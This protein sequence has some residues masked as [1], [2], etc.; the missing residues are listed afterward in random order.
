M[1]N[2]P[3]LPP[4]LAP[5][6]SAAGTCFAA[7]DAV[8]IPADEMRMAEQQKSIFV[9]GAGSGI[10]R[11]TAQLFAERGWFVGLFDVNP[12][13]LSET[14][15]SLPEGQRISMTF[16]VRDRSG[17]ARAVEAFGQ[18]TGRRMH[19]LFNNAGVG[20]GGW[21]EEM[22]PDDI[23][24]VIDVNLKGVIN[25]AIAALPLLREAPGA[26][27][28]NTASVAGV[29]GAPRMA[30]Y[31]ATKFGVRG[32]T[33][34]LD[35]EYSRY[36]IRVVSLMPWFVDTAILDRGELSS[37]RAMRDQ[38]IENKTP[39]YPVR[40]AAERAWDAA[41]GEDI[42]YMVG[43]EAERARFAARFFPNAMRKRL[44]RMLGDD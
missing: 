44:K 11:A 31:C 5:D 19:V 42:H 35:V 40:M 28:V 26:R 38:L 15:A 25:G 33:E 18:A 4:L 17:W 1:S 41:H 22:A 14:A 6:A 10:G 37:N 16:D 27:I 21:L 32:L 43:K 13:G 36:G 12:D 3:P 9:T 2:S 34:S 39:I 24:L 29:F 20:R 23:D 7:L 30:V 8:P